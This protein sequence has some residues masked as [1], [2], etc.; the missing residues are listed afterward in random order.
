MH[1]LKWVSSFNLTFISKMLTSSSLPLSVGILL[2]VGSGL[3]IG[4][5]FVF[6]KKGLLSAQKKSGS[7]IGEGHSYL[8]S[9]LWW[10]G[11]SLSE[12]ISTF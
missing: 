9:P 12:F 11:M 7:Q 10:T 3:F 5:S 8:K 2:A 4:S 1:H 6:K